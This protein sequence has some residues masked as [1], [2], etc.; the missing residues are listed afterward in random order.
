MVASSAVLQ[1]SAYKETYE[2]HE[3]RF[4]HT[5][6][7]C[8]IDPDPKKDKYL[9]EDDVKWILKESK[10]AISEWEVHL[11]DKAVYNKEKAKWEI[12]YIEIPLADQ[13]KF[14]YKKC[15]IFINF[16]A[17][18]KD[19]KDWY[20][21]IGESQYETNSTGRTNIIAY[22]AGIQFCLTQDPNYFYYNPC[23]S[24]KPRTST[25]IANVIRHEFGHA[26]GLGHYIS[27][28]NEINLRWARGE[29]TAPSIMA[30]FSHEV[31][32]E[33]KI[34]TIDIEK[35]YSLYGEQGFLRN[36][37]KPYMGFESF[38]TL[39]DQHVKDKT[40]TN[41]VTI[42]GNVTSELYRQGQSV[43]FTLT[44][45]DKQKEKFSTKIDADAGFEM[46][47]PVDMT[48]QEGTY[49]LF[50][51]YLN[52]TSKEITFDVLANQDQS[53][54]STQKIPSWIKN[55]AKWWSEN[56]IADN[57]F[58]E[59]IKYLIKEGIIKIEPIQE[60]NAESD[61]RNIPEWIKTTAGWWANDLVPE[62][63][64]I[65]GM[66]YLVQQGIILFK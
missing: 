19:K 34:Q 56:Q 1:S 32:S 17:K 47:Y 4:F 43:D 3:P 23:Y 24:E 51:K 14:D 38:T 12:N 31:S 5:P 22:Y 58:V 11:Q 48:T 10:V 7:V 45:P 59:G 39:K 6:T 52:F 28:D 46:V 40:Q 25:Q 30:I 20:S 49:L 44:K 65:R 62:D 13:E 37:P 57:D 2:V 9:S 15:D 61:G 60:T 66:Q 35:V 18:P 41:Y 29:A 33:N 50:A 36:V 8:T 26:L 16:E 42:V 63:D 54:N 27:D 53:Y 55:S 21:M 64:F